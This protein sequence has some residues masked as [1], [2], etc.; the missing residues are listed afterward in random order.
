MSEESYKLLA[1]IPTLHITHTFILKK[2]RCYLLG[3]AEMELDMLV[4]AHD[5]SLSRRQ[6]W[7]EIVDDVLHVERHPKA[8][9]SLN[10]DPSIKKL[11]LKS[12]ETFSAGLTIFRFIIAQDAAG[13]LAPDLTYTLSAK[14]FSSKLRE[15]NTRNF[16]EVVSEMPSLTQKNETTADFFF[17]LVRYTA[18]SRSRPQSD[19]L[20]SPMA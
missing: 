19:R 8:S 16:L 10:G 1:S 9:Q 2:D 5:R 12:G 11:Q 6:A 20:A 14:E 18:I 17:R 7:L 15:H 3:S 13:Q 4:F